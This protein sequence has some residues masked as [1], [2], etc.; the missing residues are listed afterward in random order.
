MEGK[1]R[2][3]ERQYQGGWR[4]AERAKRQDSDGQTDRC[5]GAEQDMTDETR[6]A[7]SKEGDD[8]DRNPR[9]HAGHDPL[10]SGPHHVSCIVSARSTTGPR[11][12]GMAP[13]CRRIYFTRMPGVAPASGER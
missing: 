2:Q 1:V 11:S 9:S 8:A 12:P 3:S 7:R 5:A 10:Q 6:I 4:I 13:C